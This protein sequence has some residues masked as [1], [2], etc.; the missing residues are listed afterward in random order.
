MDEL[1]NDILGHAAAVIT[2]LSVA[3]LVGDIFA[4][5]L[6]RRWRFAYIFLVPVVA[7]IALIINIVA[8]RRSQRFWAIAGILITLL[9]IWASSLYAVMA[10]GF[11]AM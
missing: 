4:D 1:K 11:R 10:W 8:A 5:G 2:A 6:G 7:L 3:M 9:V